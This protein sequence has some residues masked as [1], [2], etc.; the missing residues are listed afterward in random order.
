MYQSIF[1][2][3]QSTLAVAQA[4]AAAH[5]PQVVVIGGVSYVTSAQVAAQD[6]LAV[7]YNPAQAGAAAFAVTVPVPLDP[8]TSVGASEAMELG[9]MVAAVWVGVFCIKYIAGIF[10]TRSD[11]FDVHS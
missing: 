11:D 1:G 9:W 5:V 8:C 3:V 2:C 6:H 10:T 7:T 4:Q